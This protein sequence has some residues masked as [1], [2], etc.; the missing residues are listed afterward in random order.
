MQ[1]QINIDTREQDSQLSDELRKLAGALYEGGAPGGDRRESYPAFA[2]E[3]VET[4][5]RIFSGIG[6]EFRVCIM[7]SLFSQIAM[8]AIAGF[9]HK[10]GLFERDP[11]ERF[12]DT[13][14][15]FVQMVNDPD[16]PEGRQ[17]LEKI[18]AIH[19]RV[20]VSPKLPEFE[21]VVYT[22]TAKLMDTLR[23][24][25]AK[26]PTK[27]EEEAWFRVWRGVG[28]RLGAESI[29]ADYA[30][31]R[32][33]NEELEERRLAHPSKISKQVAD[34]LI[35]RGIPTLPLLLQPVGRE[36]ITAL[37]EPKIA[38]ALGLREASELERVTTRVAVQTSSIFLHVWRGLASGIG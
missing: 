20:G 6:V 1:A 17:A 9:L 25:D 19:E 21:Y 18:R 4:V 14:A 10:T 24:Y 3:D 29:P 5:K 15:F 36:L 37:L 11:A 13:R 23:Q 8:P 32:R 16:S 7:N 26:A 2:R 22:L 38:R 28:I 30:E 12:R 27:A 35:E 34:T 33:K 31:F